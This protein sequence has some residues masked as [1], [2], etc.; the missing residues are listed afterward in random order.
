VPAIPTTSDIEEAVTLIDSAI[1]DFRFLYDLNADGIFVPTEQ[2]DSADM[3]FSSS[4]AN[5]IG[6]ISTAFVR[7]ILNGPTPL[8]A[9]TAPAPGTGKTLLAEQAALIA[10]GRPAP[11]FSAPEDENRD[12]GV[13]AALQG[14]DGDV[15]ADRIL[16]YTQTTLL[17]VNCIWMATGNNL[18]V[19]ATCRA[20]VIGFISTQRP[21]PLIFG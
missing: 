5:L 3:V 12:P 20:G 11:L 16:G 14:V 17:P 18:R 7:P 15:W 2:R 8:A 9:I 10:T 1:G 4:R 6:T 21:P 13:G 19:A